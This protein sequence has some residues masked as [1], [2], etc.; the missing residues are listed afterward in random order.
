M[1]EKCAPSI[2]LAEVIRVEKDYEKSVGYC[3]VA[4]ESVVITDRT[5]LW[6]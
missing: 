3:Q 6:A 2:V 5:H 4:S 1:S